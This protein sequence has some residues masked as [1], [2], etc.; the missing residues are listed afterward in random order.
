MDVQ[1][2][3]VV[4]TRNHDQSHLKSGMHHK[5]H[6]QAYTTQ[7]LASTSYLHFLTIA[8][9]LPHY[10]L[11]VV[12]SANLT[13]AR[14][15]LTFGSSS[16]GLAVHLPVVKLNA[17]SATRS[18]FSSVRAFLRGGEGVL[19]LRRLGDLRRVWDAGLRCWNGL[20]VRCLR[21][22]TGL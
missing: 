8:L 4:F 7:H 13:P 22:A 15:H 17:P 10:L 14:L 12:S 20:G 3:Y 21:R 18:R 11:A 9:H 1:R 6:F 19:R 5:T 2:M 16:L